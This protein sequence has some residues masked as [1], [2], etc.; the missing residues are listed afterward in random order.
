MSE[1]G[2]RFARREFLRF[3]AGSPLLF[4]ASS[5]T[6]EPIVIQPSGKPAPN[7]RLIPSPDFAVNVFDFESVAQRNLS[8]A[9]YAFLSLGIQDEFTL[10]ANREAFGRFQLRPRRLVDV[11]DLETN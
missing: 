3:L 2:A 5:C 6:N 9:H 11:R 10:R 8:E 4:A 1:H 7:D